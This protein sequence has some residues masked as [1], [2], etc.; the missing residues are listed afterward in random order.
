MRKK[1]TQIV[2]PYDAE[3]FKELGWYEM[4]EPTKKPSLAEIEKEKQEKDNAFKQSRNLTMTEEDK[5]ISVINAVKILPPT[6][7][8]IYKGDKQPKLSDVEAIC[9]FK[10]TAEAV[11]AA[12]QAALREE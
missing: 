2:V 8:I 6:S 3:K 4:F 9:G 5:Q 12:V 7:W 10:V 11:K 1:G